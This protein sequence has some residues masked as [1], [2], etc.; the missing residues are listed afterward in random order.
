M[1]TND[2]KFQIKYSKKD[3]YSVN[4]YNLY[5]STVTY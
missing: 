4:F 3:N 2:V 5:K 1:I